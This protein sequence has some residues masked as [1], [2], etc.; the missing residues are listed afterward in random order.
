MRFENE[1][2]FLAAGIM[3]AVFILSLVLRIIFRGKVVHSNI[4]GISRGKT[5]APFVVYLPDIL[6]LAAVILLII[7]LL[8]PQSVKK[9]TEEVIKGIDI[10]AVLDVS[11]SMQAD[12]LKPNRLEAAKKVINDFVSGLK[13]DR[14]GMVVFAGKSFTQCPL[15]ND[16][17]IIRTF[18]EQINFE[19]VKIDGTAV[20][21]AI[22][23]G[24]NRLESSGASKVMIV[25]T[26]GRSNRGIMPEEAAKIAAYKGIKIYTIGIGKKG[27]AQAYGFDIYGNRRPY[28]D[29]YG[30]PV[31]Y[32]EPDEESLGRVAAVTG[33]RYFRATDNNALQKIYDTIAQLEKQEIK[34]KNYEK[35]ED[36]FYAFL[37]A[38]VILLLLALLLEAVKL[39]RI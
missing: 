20:G 5:T 1:N 3:A 37:I 6:K 26:D 13:N 14:V 9:E 15:T 31:M 25:T 33:G 30:R 38:G 22:L 17:E 18:I 2:L 11:G 4:K 24:V 32:E 35:H 21:E 28:V 7:A 19:T 27:G 23:N 12:D 39:L 36:K 29:N 16:Y 10:I 8:R 34:V